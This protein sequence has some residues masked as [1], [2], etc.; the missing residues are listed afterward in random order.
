VGQTLRLTTAEAAFVL[1]EPVRA[2]KKALDEGPIRAALVR[3]AG[4]SVR[5]LDRSDL[6]YLFAARAL[7]DE[8]TPKA[9]AELYEA[10]KAGAGEAAAVICFGRLSIDVSDFQAELD[11]RVGR[12][13]ELQ[14]FVEFRAD[15]EALIAGA[16]VEVHRIA[17]LLDGGATAEAVLA[18][19]PSLTREQVMSALAYAGAHP[20]PGRPYP[21]K[22][23]KRALSS[24]GLEAL[25]EV[26]GSPDEGK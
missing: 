6:V 19:Y 20:K 21:R 22:S 15:G 9:R 23:L 24:A 3:K 10:L 11:Q 26:L 4:A 2:I 25:D 12:L 16:T 8:I 5:A 7:K 14:D 17:A 13:A 1:E 18:D